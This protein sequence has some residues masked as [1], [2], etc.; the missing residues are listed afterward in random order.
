MGLQTDFAKRFDLDHPLIVAPMAGGPSSVDLV[1]ESSLAGALGSAGAAYLKPAEIEKFDEKVRAKTA[2]PFAINLFVPAS[3]PPVS[4]AQLQAAI[5]ATSKYRHEMGLAEPVLSPPYE[6]D[7]A[8]QFAKVMD[9]KP[10]VLSFV[11][12]LLD[13]S[14]VDDAKKRGIFLIG[15]A[16]SYEE[17]QALEASGVDAITLQ[18]VEAGGHR[19]I[20]DATAKDPQVKAFDLLQQ[21]IGKIKA[22]LIAAGGIMNR[23]QCLSA[24]SLGAQAVQMGTAFLACKEAGTSVP[25]REALLSTNRETK[26]T[27]VFSGRLAR[28]IRNRFMTEMEALGPGAILPFPAQNKFTRDLRSAS[29]K[30]HS[31]DFLSLWAGTGAGD[32]WQGSCRDLIF[33]LFDS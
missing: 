7:F 27:R 30:R 24:L 15:T 8:A 23:Q 14:Y 1:A 3:L 9:I 31:P 26:T 5:N 22:P 2:K 21:C 6:E 4:H 18:G 28:G 11:F 12:G 25:Y 10:A 17:A 32:L 19:G 29:V 20:F 16:T 33:S 13:P